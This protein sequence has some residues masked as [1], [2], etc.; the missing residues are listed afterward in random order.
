MKILTFGEALEL[1][2]EISRDAAGRLNMLGRHILSRGFARTYIA[3]S[4]E[5]LS[6]EKGVPGLFSSDG[7]QGAWFDRAEHYAQMLTAV[8][9]S[10]EQRPVATLVQELA[11]QGTRRREHMYASLLYN[12]RFAFSTLQGCAQPAPAAVPA[13]ELLKTPSLEQQSPN[14]PL[15][16]GC[17]RL[18]AA[19]TQS[20]GS[21]AEFRTLLLNSSLAQS[22]DGFTWLVA[23]CAGDTGDVLAY[24][25]LFVFNTYNAGTPYAVSR[26]EHFK[27]VAATEAGSKPMDGTEEAVQNLQY[28][29][30]TRY[31]PLLAID[32]SPKSWLYDYGVFGKA[33]YLDRVW[34]STNWTAVESRLPEQRN[35]TFI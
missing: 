32:S 17:T 29:A 23:R 12:L 19:L 21:I 25:K 11:T 26:V 28:K 18:H 3:P 4:L 10:G 14:E 15:E 34:E 1:K 30:T 33:A 20:F 6:R 35:E 22:G 13:A 7:L 2:E 24:D 8:A 5:H 27:R 16:A 9:R 31:L